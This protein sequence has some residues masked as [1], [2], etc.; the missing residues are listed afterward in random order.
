MS[1]YIN[2]PVCYAKDVVGKDPMA[3]FLGIAVDEVKEGYA[4]C[5]LTITPEY[6][7]AVER[8]HGAIIY[9]LIDQSL[10]VA[11]NSTG[12]LAMSLNVS[13]NYVASARVGEK[14]FGEAIP[15]KIGKKVSLWK[16]DVRSTEDVLI[17]T[18]DGIAYHK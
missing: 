11:S 13:V 14:L 4:R 3:Q 10:A 7:N 12:M 8:A 15:V 18:A 16:I 5:S 2:D 9:A 6:L 17:A 1:N